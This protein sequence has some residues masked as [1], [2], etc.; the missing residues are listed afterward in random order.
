MKCYERC[1]LDD[2]VADRVCFRLH[3][4]IE[5]FQTVAAIFE[6]RFFHAGNNLFLK[7]HPLSSKAFKTILWR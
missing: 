1:S 3:L 4:Q 2:F 6:L 7:Q 5:I